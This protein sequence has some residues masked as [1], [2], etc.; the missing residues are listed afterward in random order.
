MNWKGVGLPA[1]Q[2]APMLCVRYAIPGAHHMTYADSLTP[3][4]KRKP[5]TSMHLQLYMI[6]HP[7]NTSPPAG[8]PEVP[9]RYVGP[10]TTTPFKVEF[11]DPA[12]YGTWCASMQVRGAG[13]NNGLLT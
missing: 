8:T 6:V 7:V 10:I 4:F 9:G 5:H 13:C 2:T 3:A 1:P 11:K 12:G